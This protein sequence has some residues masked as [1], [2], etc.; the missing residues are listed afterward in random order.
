MEDD[1]TPE[2]GAPEQLGGEGEAEP[3]KGGPDQTQALLRQLR[4]LQ[5][6]RDQLVKADADRKD[7]ELGEVE[8]LRKQLTDLQNE[9]GSLK[10]S[11]RELQVR[12]AFEAEAIRAG[13]IDSDAAYRLAD[14]SGVELDETG[15][16]V[17]VKEAIK[18]LKDS[19]AF[20][21]G[22]VQKAPPGG[23]AAGGGN[24]QAG[25]PAAKQVVTEQMVRSMSREDFQKLHTQMV[26]GRLTF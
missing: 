7:S 15:K 11:M 3:V 1:L 14:L 13:V 2:T 19:R 26:G 23:V 12:N 10:G 25:N 21:F 8:K 5:K 4:K 9:N 24:P 17:G 16:L 18:G 20:L 22:Q 6:E